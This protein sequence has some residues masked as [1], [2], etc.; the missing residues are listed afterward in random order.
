MRR[1][2][3]ILTALI[4]SCPVHAQLL[5]Q[6]MS[7]PAGSFFTESFGDTGAQPC[8]YGAPWNLGLYQYTGCN[9][10]WGGLTIGS[11]G[12][13]SIA[14][15]P[16]SASYPHGKYSLKVVTSTAATYLQ[17]AGFTPTVSASTPFDLQFSLNVASSSLA[18]GG[19]QPIYS[20]S[21]YVGAGTYPCRVD[22]HSS[23][24][25]T[26]AIRG[27]G[28][29]TSADSGFL[30]LNADHIVFMHCV[31][32]GAANS[33]YV[34]LDGGTH[35][36][37]TAGA[38]AWTTQIIGPWTG[39]QAAITYY[40]GNALINASVRSAGNGPPL[41]LN[42]EGGTNGAALSPTNL[43]AS[44]IGGN[45]SWS[46]CGTDPQVFTTAAQL[47]LTRPVDVLGV[48]YTDA[49]A[50][51]GDNFPLAASVG[52]YCPYAWESFSPVASDF[53]WIATNV[54]TS[55][56]S[57]YASMNTFAN[58]RGSDFVSHMVNS[59]LLYL[60]VNANPN[61]T[62]DVGSQFAY[63]PGA[64]YGVAAQYQQ[65]SAGS[66]PG[67]VYLVEGTFTSGTFVAGETLTQSTSG[68]KATLM[69]NPA[70]NQSLQIQMISGTATSTG[71]WTGGSSGAVFTPT[72]LPTTFHT[73]II[74]DAS[75]NVLSIQKKLANSSNPAPPAY[76][77]IGRVGD[78]NKSGLSA[79]FYTDNVFLD[80]ATGNMI[81]CH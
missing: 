44:T 43:A 26:I 56:T 35:L 42:F 4:G 75:C 58:E 71:K 13:I 7:A 8:G 49:T 31:P 41:Y 9:V 32:G 76:W 3:L 34:T 10:I 18:S 22:F 20:F 39:T 77:Y 47:S 81:P 37:F 11:G 52:G 63:T 40:I 50:T 57:T 24:S 74:Y 48:Q 64:R 46:S 53:E 70:G 36:T 25:G 80:Y 60:E 19:A 66:A 33:S 29:N 12:S 68:A 21:P 15:S 23:S 73:L 30:T 69:T 5:G 78:Q 28:S 72:S 14:P 54:P 45:G 65:Y 67:G 17:S 1:L 62:P 2:C 16:G 55:D 51:L 79:Y 59:G 61:G 6:Q 27:N 38:L